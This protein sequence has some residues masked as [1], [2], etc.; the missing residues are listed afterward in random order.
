MREVEFGPVRRRIDTGLPLRRA[1][2][3]CLTAVVGGF[4]VLLLGPFLH[5]T[6]VLTQGALPLV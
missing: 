5:G 6:L 4:P 1:A 2:L 3:E